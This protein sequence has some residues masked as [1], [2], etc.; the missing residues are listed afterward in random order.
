MRKNY[1]III[2]IAIVF[3]FVLVF[4]V[5]RKNNSVTNISQNQKQTSVET[6]IQMPVQSVPTANNT[7]QLPISQAK[8]RVTKKPFGLFVTPQNSPVSPEKFYGYHTGTDFET[9]PDEADSNVSVYV[10]TPGKII[11]KRF[12]SGYGGVLVESAQVNNSPVTIIYGHLNLASI[13]K[14]TGDSLSAGEQI[15]FLGKGYSSQT[16]GERKHLHLGIHKGSSVNILGY[17]QNKSELEGWIDP[18]SLF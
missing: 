10:I 17:V 2:P 11:M 12:A 13:N 16:D 7:L 14:K 18:M 5:K 1:K 6:A 15:G 3:I 9:F 4:A 8:N